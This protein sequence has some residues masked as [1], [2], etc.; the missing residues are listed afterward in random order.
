LGILMIRPVH[1][2]NMA[3][4]ANSRVD[5][6]CAAKFPNDVWKCL[7]PQYFAEFLKTPFFVMNSQYDTSELSYTL[8]LSDQ[9]YSSIKGDVNCTTAELNAIESLPAKQASAMAPLL[10]KNT[11]GAFL[12]NDFSHGVAHLWAWKINGTTWVDALDRWLHGERVILKD[13]RR[14]LSSCSPSDYS[15]MW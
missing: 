12:P 2:R 14:N 15:K 4:Y 6:G 7:F 1:M 13:P 10:A 5:M 11:T 9:C 8:A 3:R